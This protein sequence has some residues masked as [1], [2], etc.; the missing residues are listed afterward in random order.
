MLAGKGDKLTI[1][2]KEKENYM[3]YIN[4]VLFV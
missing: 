2:E 3:Q 4:I 1:K